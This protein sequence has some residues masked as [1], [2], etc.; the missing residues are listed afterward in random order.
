MKM[1]HLVLSVGVVL[2]VTL[3]A[4]ASITGPTTVRA[5][6]GASPLVATSEA[7]PPLRNVA[8]VSAG[9]WHSCALTT[10][11]GV[12]C[13]GLNAHGQV[14]DGTRTSASLPRDVIGL[15]SGV[16]AIAAGGSHTCALTTAGAVKC[17]GRNAE[18]QLGDG[19]TTESLTPVDV[20]G[21]S[22]GVVAIAAGGYH[23]CALTAA[24][25][26]KCWGDNGY[27]AVGDG[28]YADR[29]APVSVTG[30]N[31]GVAA[32]AT[33]GYQPRSVGA[34][35]TKVNWETAHSRPAQRRSP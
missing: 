16:A 22:S 10:S 17:W 5:A 7:L 14:G 27:G 34:R 26:V 4:P 19:T 18:G 35:T 23:T 8:A 6:P 31:S 11:G 2:L 25:A 9:G 28:S 21:L 30:L 3:V 29:S 20:V 32:I 24:G 13:W 12:K 1:L 15:T 33:G